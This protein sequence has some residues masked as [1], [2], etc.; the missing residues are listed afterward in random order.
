MQ[1]LRSMQ[2]LGAFACVPTQ[3]PLPIDPSATSHVAGDHG[4]TRTALC[5]D[6]QCPPTVKP[7]VRGAAGEYESPVALALAYR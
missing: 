2:C 5:A 7:K 3:V 4:R 1:V 6:Y